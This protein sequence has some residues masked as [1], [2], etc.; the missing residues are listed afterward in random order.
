MEYVAYEILDCMFP[1]LPDKPEYIKTP[2]GLQS[3][4]YAKTTPLPPWP[5]LRQT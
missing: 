5:P 3:T 4:P 2:R 1:D